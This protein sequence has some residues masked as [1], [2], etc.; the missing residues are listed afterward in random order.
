MDIL[1]KT[2]LEITTLERVGITPIVAKMAESH[3]RWFRHVLRR[4][5]KSLVRRIDQMEGKPIIGL[6]F[7]VIYD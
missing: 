1:N 4:L 2:G 7:D 3:L 6:S 5:V